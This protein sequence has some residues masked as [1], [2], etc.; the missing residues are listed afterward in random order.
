M[1]KDGGIILGTFNIG[2]KNKQTT[3]SNV[4]LS[5]EQIH[6]LVGWNRESK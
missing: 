4:I 1:N 5:W 6:R 3:I 2:H